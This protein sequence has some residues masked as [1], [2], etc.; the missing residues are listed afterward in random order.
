M[1]NFLVDRHDFPPETAKWSTSSGLATS[2][3]TLSPSIPRG[4]FEAGRPTLRQKNR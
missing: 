2:P 1:I 3:T 4:A